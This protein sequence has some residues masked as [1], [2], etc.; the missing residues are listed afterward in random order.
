MG[1]GRWAMGDGCGYRAKFSPSPGGGEEIGCGLMAKF[2]HSVGGG[3]GEGRW[4]EGFM[5][6]TT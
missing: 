1:D 3:G 4:T 6:N 5:R 2:T